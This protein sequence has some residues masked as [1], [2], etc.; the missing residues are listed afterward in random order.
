[1]TSSTCPATSSDLGLRYQAADKIF[2]L[3]IAVTKSA[4]IDEG[5]WRNTGDR[6]VVAYKNR[7]HA[8]VPVWKKRTQYHKH[9][10]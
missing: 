8:T 1:M 7:D 10:W 4:L 6:S 9:L 5:F 2:P 3:M